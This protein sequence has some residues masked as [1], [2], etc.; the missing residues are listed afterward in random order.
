MFNYALLPWPKENLAMH[1]VHFKYCPWLVLLKA[2]DLQGVSPLGTSS[3]RP[4]CRPC[5]PPAPPALLCS[6][7]L[8]PRFSRAKPGLP[9]VLSVLPDKLCAP[10]VL[11]RCV[12]V[13]LLRNYLYGN[14]FSLSAF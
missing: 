12:L 4:W 6:F 8:T 7:L 2:Q 5:P 11:I 9:F 3:C 1:D 13:Q 14:M 10:L